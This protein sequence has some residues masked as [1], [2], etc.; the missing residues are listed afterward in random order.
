MLGDKAPVYKKRDIDSDIN[1]ALTQRKKIKVKTRIS[2]FGGVKE[3]V[4]FQIPGPSFVG[5]VYTKM[6][7]SWAREVVKQKKLG[8]DQYGDW[9]PMVNHEEVI[10]I[11]ITE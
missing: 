3:G 4:L 9:V 6:C 2:Y 10:P 1:D 11:E 8:V 7:G 5:K